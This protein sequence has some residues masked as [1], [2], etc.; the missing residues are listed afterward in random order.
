[1]SLTVRAGTAAYQFDGPHTNVSGLAKA[2]GVYV[3]TTVVNGLH[4]IID[5]GESHDIQTRV[6]NHDRSNSWQKHTVDTLYASALYCNE[7]T[8]MTV[9]SQIR[10][11]HNP[12]CGIR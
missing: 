7:T 8:R 3:I 6:S 1:M 11:L 12:P 9:E 5:A 4:K 10:Q 2:S